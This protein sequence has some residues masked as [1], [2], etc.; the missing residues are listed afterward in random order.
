[1][2]N[3]LEHVLVNNL[4]GSSSCSLVVIVLNFILNG[5][6]YDH[7]KITRYFQS[8][9]SGLVVVSGCP[10]MYSPIIATA[11][12][13]I[14]GILFYGIS[15]MMFQSAIEDNCNIVATHLISGILG[16]LFTA[17]SIL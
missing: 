14:N 11:L 13:S 1:M 3:K 9:I 16:S 10:E 2:S 6:F 15:E 8:L 7:W 12:G 5:R 17:L 4:L